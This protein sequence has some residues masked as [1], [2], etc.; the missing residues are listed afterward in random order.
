M[1]R[2]TKLVQITADGRDKGKV[3][4][5][6]EMSASR[7][8]KWAARALLAVGNAGTD[9]SPEIAFGG[10]AGMAVLG[11]QALAKVSFAEAEP[12]MDELFD[13]V[14]IIPDPKVPEVFRRLIED[15]IEE[16]ATRVHL[17]A[18]VWTL[19]TGFSFADA[20]SM[21]TSILIPSADSKNT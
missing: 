10:F 4:L 1:A 8:E 3:F 2:K 12:L 13:C 14:Q 18:E 21:L 19:H 5:L 6:T 9:L 15:D 16:V 20:I 11:I 17:R 7:A